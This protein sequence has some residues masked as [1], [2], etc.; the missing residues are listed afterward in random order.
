VNRRDLDRDPIHGAE[1][2][3]LADTGHPKGSTGTGFFSMECKPCM[4]P[5]GIWCSRHD[6]FLATVL[7]Q[8]PA[9]FL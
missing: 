6:P 5:K 1:I 3:S 2:L 8:V 7:P 9:A 4:G